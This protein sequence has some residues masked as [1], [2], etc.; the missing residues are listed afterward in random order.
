MGLPNGLFPSG[1]PTKILY[2][3]LLSF[4]IAAVWY[5]ELC[6]LVTKSHKDYKRNVTST[7]DISWS[8]VYTYGRCKEKQN[9]LSLVWLQILNCYY[10]S[11]LT[12][13]YCIVVR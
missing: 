12:S 1:F 3:P 10:Q 13:S 9:I 2:K 5:S 6:Y 4:H 8:K 7:S 11:I